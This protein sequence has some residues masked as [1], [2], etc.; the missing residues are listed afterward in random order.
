MS[1]PSS[2]SPGQQPHKQPT[3][4]YT[5]MLIVSLLAI[6]T[7]T[8]ILAIELNR[9]G[10]YPWWEVPAGGSAPAGS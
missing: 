5:V 6:I 1:L 3:N 9:F 8:T 2:L 10:E 4:I 7:A